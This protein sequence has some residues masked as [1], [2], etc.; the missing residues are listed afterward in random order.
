MRGVP[1]W[2]KAFTIDV[3]DGE[4]FAPYDPEAPKRVADY[5]RSRGYV[6]PDTPEFQAYLKDG[7]LKP[8]YLTGPELT[9]WMEKEDK[10]HHDLMEKGGLLKK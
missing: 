7:A 3:G 6:F 10:V 1:A 8:A 2:L 4:T 5:A 9:A